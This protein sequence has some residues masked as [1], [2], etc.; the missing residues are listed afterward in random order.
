MTIIICGYN[1][2]VTTEEDKNG[3]VDGVSLELSMV[4]GGWCEMEINQS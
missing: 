2:S 4:D 3:T 1:V